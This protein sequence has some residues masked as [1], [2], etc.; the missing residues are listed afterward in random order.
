MN[1]ELIE[2]GDTRARAVTSLLFQGLHEVG[3]FMEML[4]TRVKWAKRQEDGERWRKWGEKTNMLRMNH[5]A[6]RKKWTCSCSLA[7]R[8]SGAPNQESGIQKQKVEG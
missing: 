2:T 5:R 6:R 8:S 1:I 4:R 7:G 3:M